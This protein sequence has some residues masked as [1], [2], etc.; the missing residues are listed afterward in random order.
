MDPP[1]E[2]WEKHCLCRL[3]LNPDFTY[4][5]CDKCQ[6]W[7]HMHCIGITNEE[8]EAID[9]YVCDKCKQA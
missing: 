2:T 9:E 8:A 3:P 7:Y 1:I 6:T 5:Q 4:I